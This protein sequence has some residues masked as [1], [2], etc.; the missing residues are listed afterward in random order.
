MAFIV[1]VAQMRAIETEA[2][3]KGVSF[4]RMMDHAGEAVFSYALLRHGPV[5][6][7]R[8]IILC[9][10]G[11]N[12]GDGLAAAAHFARAGAEVRALLL[13]PRSESDP[14]GRAAVEAGAALVPADTESRLE[15]LLPLLD[16]ADILV[17]AVLGTGIKLPLRPPL[18]GM[19]A[20]IKDRLENSIRRPFVVALDCPSGLDCDSG[21][22]APQTIPADLTVTLGAAKAGLLAFPGAEYVGSLI[23]A[24]IGLPADLAALRLTGPVLADRGLVRGW[25]R[26]RPRDSHKGTFGR[27]IIIGGSIN[28]SGAPIL[29]G[30]GAYRAGAG[31]V[32]LAVP[33]PVY[34]AAIPLL[35]EATW[36]AVPEDMGVIAAGAADVLRPEV[37]HAQ[38]IVIGPGLGREKSTGAFMKSFLHDGQVKKTTIGFGPQEKIEPEIKGPRPPMLVDADGL[39]MLSEMD[40]WPGL[41]PAGSILTPHPGEMSAL[42]GLSK[43]DIQKDRSGVAV[44]F[45]KLW[46]A[47]VIL[48]G[49]FSVVAAPDGRCA[50]EPFATP[51]L[52]RAGTGDVLAG[53]VGGLLAQGMESWQAA[54]LGAF[55]HGRA[56]ELAAADVGASDS[57][58]AGDVARSLAKAIAEL[59]GNI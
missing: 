11:N 28:Y 23:V 7:Q 41:L 38:A 24:E 58:L 35:P 14:R 21:A 59:R 19:L 26:P 18:A 4:E 25:L 34:P 22:A 54:V 47:V 5:E 32:T 6:K 43:E 50:I 16:G 31:L 52:A 46:N 13:A 57:V 30:M 3:R 36:I 8:V 55:L 51:A 48:K 56:G 29:A 27:V 37:A 1:S 53:T 10:S 15:A 9:G 44:R 42:T 40:G 20:A 12:G 45:A 49:A 2:D 17:D 33:S 39:R